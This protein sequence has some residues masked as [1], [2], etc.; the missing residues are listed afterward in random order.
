MYALSFAGNRFKLAGFFADSASNAKITVNQSDMPVIKVS[1]HGARR[2]D[3]GTHHT[4]DAFFLVNDGKV[5]FHHDCVKFAGFHAKFAADTADFAV[6][7][8]Q[9]TFFCGAAQ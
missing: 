9:I 1:P 6:V 2:A 4:T 8:D 5:V 3:F 7:A